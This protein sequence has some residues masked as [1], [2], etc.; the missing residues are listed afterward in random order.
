MINL[1]NLNGTDIDIVIQITTEDR[2][3]D[4]IINR[5]SGKQNN[6]KKWE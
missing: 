6:K 5:A 1:K 3:N 4:L 2:I